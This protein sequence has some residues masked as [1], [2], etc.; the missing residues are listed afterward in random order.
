MSGGAEF[1]PKALEQQEEELLQSRA[2]SA[3]LE[4]I[5]W[6]KINLITRSILKFICATMNFDRI[7]LKYINTKQQGDTRNRNLDKED[8]AK[9]SKDKHHVE[10]MVSHRAVSSAQPVQEHPW[11]NP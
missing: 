9:G 3:F 5:K 4:I 6:Y 1:D 2:T 11:P 8:A 7:L 10:V